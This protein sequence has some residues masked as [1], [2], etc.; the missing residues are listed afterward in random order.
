MDD[1]ESRT[2]WE[3]EDVHNHRDDHRMSAL[4]LSI[5][6]GGCTTTVVWTLRR[7]NKAPALDEN[8]RVQQA[9]TDEDEVLSLFQSAVEELLIHGGE[10]LHHYVFASSRYPFR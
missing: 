8:F 1:L 6:H 2:G 5:S 7:V 4:R 9:A 10:V 3:R